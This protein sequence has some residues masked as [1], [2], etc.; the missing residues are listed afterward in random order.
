MQALLSSKLKPW[1]AI[2]IILI[3]NPEH[4]TTPANKKKINYLS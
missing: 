4:S 3:L 1:C 2:N